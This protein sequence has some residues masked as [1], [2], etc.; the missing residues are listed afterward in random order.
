MQLLPIILFHVLLFDLKNLLANGLKNGFS[1]S[2]ITFCGFIIDLGEHVNPA[3]LT[4][5]SGSKFYN[6]S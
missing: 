5:R 2:F 3:I 6:L 1:E 4:A